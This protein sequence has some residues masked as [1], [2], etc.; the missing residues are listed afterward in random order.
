MAAPRLAYPEEDEGRSNADYPAAGQDGGY[1]TMNGNIDEIDNTSRPKQYPYKP[2]N[3]NNGEVQDGYVGLEPPRV[4]NQSMSY[5][6]QADGAVFDEQPVFAIDSLGQFDEDLAVNN[7]PDDGQYN[8]W[9]SQSPGGKSDHNQPMSALRLDDP[10]PTSN[11]GQELPIRPGRRGHNGL[12]VARASAN[13]SYDSDARFADGVVSNISVQGYAG[14]DAQY[15]GGYQQDGDTR[16]GLVYFEQD[17]QNR[18]Q[19]HISDESAV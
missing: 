4:L 15:G 18:A 3:H 17:H 11:C 2:S 19:I 6:A 14:V 7:Y 13:V 9:R 16:N 1:S 8:A 10:S 5:A 12:P